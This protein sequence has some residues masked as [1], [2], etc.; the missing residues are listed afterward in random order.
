MARARGWRLTLLFCVLLMP[1]VLADE[2]FNIRISPEV[3]YE[4]C[5]VRVVVRVPPDA[6]NRTL[7]IEADSPMYFR[8]SEID[9]S[10]ESA[11]LLHTLT[12]HSP[13]SGEYVIRARVARANSTTRSTQRSLRVIGPLEG[14][15]RPSAC[16][17]RCA[18]GRKTGSRRQ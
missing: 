17:P 7:I 13:P 8:G 1:G 4:G 10:G 11:A 14:L 6:E 2:G 5:D 15:P 3:C 9:L 12:L 18:A 16:A